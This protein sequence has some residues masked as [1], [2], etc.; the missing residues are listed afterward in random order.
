MAA[1]AKPYRTDEAAMLGAVA[2]FW[3]TYYD[4]LRAAHLAQGRAITQPVEDRNLQTTSAG[5]VR[6]FER[7]W[8]DELANAL[9][10]ARTSVGPA[11]IQFTPYRSKAFDVCYPLEGD[12][13]ILISIK[14]MQNAYRNITNRVEEALGDSSVLRIYDS[15]AAFG[16]FYF[17]LDGPVARGG[18][19]QG[20][21]P[22]GERVVSAPAD[23]ETAEGEVVELVDVEGGAKR[24]KIAPYLTL[25]EQ[26]GDFF[27]LGNINAY[28]KVARPTKSGNARAA[29]ETARK[30]EIR[31][32]ARS[33]IDLVQKAPSEQT[34]PKYDAMS[35][36]P[37]TIAR[38][39]DAGSFIW[40]CQISQVD[41]LVDYSLF[42]ERLVA[43]ARVRGL[44]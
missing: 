42:I 34:N 16:F 15:K 26:G 27:D 28:R 31:D 14:S 33:L 32:I 44:L 41:P 7:F 5:H 43:T 25:I 38:S 23:R 35:L 30:D 9:G 24:K 4:R 8:G 40:N 10:V 36:L 21:W 29:R 13:K 11:K 20:I 17:V 6:V 22:V 37:A 2:S 12:P 1:P 39:E 3:A 18:V 19:P